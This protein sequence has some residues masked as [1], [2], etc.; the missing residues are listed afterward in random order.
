[1][2][3]RKTPKRVAN[4]GEN[5]IKNDCSSSKPRSS[6]QKELSFIRTTTQSANFR[7]VIA[8]ADSHTNVLPSTG[9][10]KNSSTKKKK[11]KKKKEKKI[12]YIAS[13]L[14]F[15]AFKLLTVV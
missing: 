5:S 8:F 9:Q 14:I 1:M 11:R 10:E 13:H 12:S 15:L 4:K 7:L 3:E 2:A 6:D